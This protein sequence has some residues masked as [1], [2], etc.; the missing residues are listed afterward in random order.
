[1]TLPRRRHPRLPAT[2]Y[3]RVGITVLVTFCVRQRRP[4]LA[5]DDRLA[6]VIVEQLGRLHRDGWPVLG[7]CVMPDHVHV[8]VRCD[9]GPVADFVRLLKGR[10]AAAFR[11]FGLRS[12]WQRS[13]YDRIIRD[14]AALGRALRYVVLDPVRSGLVPRWHDHPWSGSLEWPEKTRRIRNRD[15]PA[16][17]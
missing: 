11:R 10:T 7:Y 14:D 12:F 1:M 4:C 8:V 2:S 16:S 17:T 5:R 13:F 3:R 6:P 9:G 15:P